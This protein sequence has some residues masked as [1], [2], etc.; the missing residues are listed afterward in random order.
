M[1]G[2]KEFDLYSI[3]AVTHGLPANAVQYRQILAHIVGREMPGAGM[4]AL[5]VGPACKEWLREQHPQLAQIPTPPDFHGDERAMDAWAAEQAA[6][7]GTDRLPVLPLPEHRRPGTGMGDFVNQV[8]NPAKVVIVDP[9]Q[10]DFGLGFADFLKGLSNMV[11]G[12]TFAEFY[13]EAQRR[14]K[15]ALDQLVTA[16]WGASRDELQLSEAEFTDLKTRRINATRKAESLVAE[17]S[18]VLAQVDPERKP[19]NN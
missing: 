8:A 9:T 12:P 16:A 19:R 5:T 7:L 13:E 18:K 1:S 14:L 10:P 17:A 3:L 11:Y 6:R 2:A 15:V 4:A